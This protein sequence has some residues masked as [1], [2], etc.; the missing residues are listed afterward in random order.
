MATLDARQSATGD[1]RPVTGI[2]VE[3]IS[4][5]QMR[6]RAHRGERFEEALANSAGSAHQETSWTEK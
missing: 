4:G 6:C 5:V 2:G 1:R 3:S